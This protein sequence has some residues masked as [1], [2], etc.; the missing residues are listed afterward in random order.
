VTTLSRS[1]RDGKRRSPASYAS[2]ANI[3][4][5]RDEHPPRIEFTHKSM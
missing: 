3:C 5:I 4:S 2:G 1:Q